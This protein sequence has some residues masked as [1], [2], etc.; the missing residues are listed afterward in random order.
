M[1]RGGSRGEEEGGELL[2]RASNINMATKKLTT[3]LAGLAVAAHPHHTL[4][5]LYGKILRCLQKMPPDASYRKYTEQIIT[6]KYNF[7]KI[8]RLFG[9][10]DSQTPDPILGAKLPSRGDVLKRA[11]YF[12][13]VEKK[14][15]A[16][17]A[18]ATVQEVLR[19]WETARIP[20]M[21]A[22]SA[23]RKVE[24][25]FKD[26]KA[27]VKSKGR[28]TNKTKEE[29]FQEAL[30]DLFDV[31]HADAMTLMTIPADREFLAAQREKGRQGIMQGADR[32]LE[33]RVQR[34]EMTVAA[35]KRSR[36]ASTSQLDERAVLASSS[37][38]SSSSVESSPARGGAAATAEPTGAS[39]PKRRARGPQ[40][41]L[42]QELA[43]ALD[44]TGVSDRKA[45]CIVAATASSLGHNPQELILNA[46]SIRQARAGY[47]SQLA[48]DK[49]R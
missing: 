34:R 19:F 27:L 13:N 42:S 2:M 14:T 32:V 45:L 41:V 4:G 10:W 1:Q 23:V 5:V 20:T 35:E 22:K 8:L 39:P 29:E 21:T 31:A 40:V 25:L 3:G 46:E 49:I 44:W 12:H 26:W 48:A 16:T 28:A 33:R 37:S 15:V 6:E 7:V 43:S 9:W 17:S 38:S 47:R 18:A 24:V 30:C 36:E 11:F